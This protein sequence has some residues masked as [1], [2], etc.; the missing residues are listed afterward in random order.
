ME[1][2]KDEQIKSIALQLLVDFSLD[3]RENGLKY[4]LVAGTLLGAV[5]HNGFIPWDDDIDVAMPR[6]DYEKFITISKRNAFICNELDD[7]YYYMFGKYYLSSTR[8]IEK[9]HPNRCKFGVYIDVFP[10]DG[11]GKNYKDATKRAKKII[12]LRRFQ[13]YS[14]HETLFANCNLYKVPFKAPFYFYAKMRGHKY[15]IDKIMKTLSVDYDTAEYVGS[16]VSGYNLRELFPKLLFEET[17]Q[18]QFEK[19]CFTSIKD[20][21]TYLSSL[22][23]DYMTL[24]KLEDRVSNHDYLAYYDGD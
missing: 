7:E 3:C 15:W 22:Y 23:G 19:C 4:F 14:I 6:A 24:P 16:I 13:N 18:Y 1:Y 2:I 17:A 10:L 9:E 20:Y 12:R 8:L 5:R 11:I 21:D